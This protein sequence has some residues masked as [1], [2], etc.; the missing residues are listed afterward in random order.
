LPS[1]DDLQPD[2][3]R[4]TSGTESWAACGAAERILGKGG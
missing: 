1:S 4:G 2:E 3:T